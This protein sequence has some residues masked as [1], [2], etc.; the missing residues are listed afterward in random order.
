MLTTYIRTSSCTSRNK[1]LTACSMSLDP[2]SREHQTS[3]RSVEH[4]SR[5]RVLISYEL[6]RRSWWCFYPDLAT[7]AARLR[8]A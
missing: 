7:R 4:M 6:S 8:E 5:F 3:F 1:D 2:E